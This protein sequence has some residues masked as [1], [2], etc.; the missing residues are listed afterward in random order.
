MHWIIKNQ[1]EEHKEA[2]PNEPALAL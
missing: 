2:Q 1:S